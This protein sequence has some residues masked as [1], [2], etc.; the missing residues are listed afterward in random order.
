MFTPKFSYTH[1]IVRNL[2]LCEGAKEV[3]ENSP[4]L[5]I[6][7]SRLQK[8]ALIRQ[9]HHTTHI[10]G[11]Q[12]TKEQ[13]RDLIDGKP[14]VARERD[15]QEVL[16]YLKVVSFIDKVF[17]D[18]DMVIDLRTIRHIHH[19]TLEGLSAGYEAGEFRKV[20][21]YVVNSKTGEVIYTPPPA[22]EVPILMMELVDWLRSE[23]AMELSPILK[24]GVAHYQ[25][26]TIHP[27][28]DGNGRTARALATLILYH[29]GYDIKKL[30]SLEEYYDANPFSYYSSLQSGRT[31]GE[32]T[33]WLE[34][35]TLGLAEEM[36]RVKGLVLV[37]SR[38]R[39]LREKIGQVGLSKRQLAILS[40]VEEHG[41]ITNGALQKFA[42]ISHSVAYDELMVLVK[43]GVLRKRGKGRGTHYIRADDF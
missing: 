23:G 11:T 21:N 40:Y 34:Y 1:S 6:W 15:K 8:D 3:I 19:L 24:A 5:P 31:T 42:R 36:Q 14:V 20:Q 39:A 25:L 12:L 16:N 29:D 4:I 22:N 26:V 18:S 30:F 32:L 38:D 35:F 10:E 43:K 28:L 41:R 17:H 2:M 37:H 27:F 13:V 9:V 7:E 33:T